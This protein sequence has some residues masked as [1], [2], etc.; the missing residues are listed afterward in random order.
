MDNQAY[1]KVTPI[2][3][4]GEDER[5]TTHDFSIRESSDFVL[6]QRKAGTI[7]GNSYHEGKKKGTSPK[8][9]VLLLGTIL[10]KYRH[11]EDKQ[12]HETMIEYPAIIEVKPLVTHSVEALSD[13]SM[14]EC[15]S[16]QEIQAD[17]IIEAVV[18]PS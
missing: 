15:N 17:R 5:G 14:L 18:Q 12:Y 13:I 16:I 2:H 8:T 10:F 3:L 9:F 7:S 4:I 1:I 6:I 11:I